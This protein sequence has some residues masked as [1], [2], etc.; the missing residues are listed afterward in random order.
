MECPVE[1]LDRLVEAVLGLPHT[2]YSLSDRGKIC[3]RILSALISKNQWKSPHIE[4][5]LNFIR[6]EYDREDSLDQFIVAHSI[7]ICEE[8]CRAVLGDIFFTISKATQFYRLFS[9]KRRGL[10]D[11]LKNLQFEPQVADLASRTG[12]SISTLYAFLRSLGS[13]FSSDLLYLKPKP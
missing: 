6:T 10:M 8:D 13:Q 4:I 11:N 1:N 12:I 5:I 2:F 3:Y 9:N 7:G